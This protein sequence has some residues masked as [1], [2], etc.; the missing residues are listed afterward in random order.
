MRQNIEEDPYGI[1]DWDRQSTSRC[2]VHIANSMVW[3]EITGD[4]PPTVAPTSTEYT[5]AGL[6][7]LEW[8]D[9]RT[10]INGSR[11]LAK[12]KSVAA[13]GKKKKQVPLP[14]NASVTPTAVVALH[15]RLKKD[16]VREFKDES[17]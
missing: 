14:E 13:M 17:S 1:N 12:L 9:D 15:A 10:P 2:F 16:Q 3:S 11:T 5:R 6:P 4:T 8:Y 7:W